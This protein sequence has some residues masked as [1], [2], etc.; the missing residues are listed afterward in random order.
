MQQYKVLKGKPSPLGVSF[1]K[2]GGINFAVFSKNC[3]AVTLELFTPQ[4]TEIPFAIIEFNPKKNKTGDIWHA[5]IN[6][7]DHNFLYLY[8]IDGPYSPQKGMRFNKNKALIDPYAKAVYGKIEYNETGIYGYDKTVRFDADLVPS[9][10]D[11]TRTS[12]KSV[13]I[14]ESNFDWEDDQAPRIPLSKSIIY[15]MH[16]RG[17]TAHSS[18]GV[19]NRG[20]FDG[21][22]EKIPYLKELGVTAIELLPVHFFNENEIIRV[23]PKTGEKL[24]NYWGYNSLSFFAL[25]NVY[26]SAKEPGGAV[27]EFK[28]MVKELHRAGIEVILDVVYNHTGEGNEVGPTISFK[29]I[30]NSVYYLLENNRY[31]KNY[32]G[33]GNTLNC[34]H[35]AVKQMIL[36]SL[37]YFVTEMHVDG[38]RFDLA[39]ILGRNAA[40]EWIGENSL[41][42]DIQEDPIL[43]GTKLIAEGWDAAGLYIVGEFLEGWAEWNGKF[44]DD[45][46]SFVKG[47]NGF[48]SAV[49]T[50]LYGSPD[51][52]ND[53]GRAPFHSINFLTSHDGFTL[54]DL[55]S[56]NSKKNFEN[57]EQN[58]DGADDNRSYNHGVEGETGDPMI[59]RLRLR[60]VKNLITLLMISQGTPMILGGDEFYRTQ[61]GNNNCYCQDNDISW[62]DWRNVAKNAELF[63][64]FK[65]IIKFRKENQ[66]FCLEKF[67]HRYEDSKTGEHID[68]IEW[69][70]VKLNAPDWSYT[71]RTLAFIMNCF[72]EV[73]G[74]P[75]IRKRLFVIINMHHEHLEFEIPPNLP[76]KK[77][78]IKLN[79]YEI[80]GREITPDDSKN[81]VAAKKIR[82]NDRSIII[83]AER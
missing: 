80:R 70:G 79:T 58:H 74:I 73:T 62:F 11:N 17:F 69:H 26:S 71:A 18:S 76:G 20:T 52:Y 63:H 34:N 75:D 23:N 16:V 82:L 37:R 49:A 19:K 27:F 68:F 1:D 48:V 78:Y 53:D 14:D 59:N 45:M 22:I 28:K 77:W 57:G 39:A 36:D 64:F 30:D 46:R 6:G 8:K 32:S 44:R 15:E 5:D 40:G 41:L 13:V 65:E 25:N 54:R 29:G 47:D 72:P 10:I 43:S 55:V 24:K 51:L 2:K 9:S 7:L 56:Y 12:L 83:L 33:C 31:Y 4:N 50:R 66:A 38:F 61:R 35:Q 60:Q 21:I 81:F 67:P 42:R 3:T